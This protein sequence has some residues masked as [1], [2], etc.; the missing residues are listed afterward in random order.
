MRP[1]RI[2][3]VGKYYP[4]VP[5]GMERFLGDLVEA[6]RAAGHD[7]T[8]LVHAEPRSDRS[9]DPPWILRCP[10][11]LRLIFAPLS[12][13]FYFW[14]RRIV[15]RFRP[16]VIHLHVPNLSAFWA[17]LVPGARDVAWVLHWQSD[18]VPSARK[19]A[20]RLAYPH[21]RIFERALLERADAVIVSS[22]QYLAGSK[23]LAPWADKC[24]VIP[25]AIDPARLPDVP[26]EATE[27]LWQGRGMRVLAV[28]RLT[29]YKGFETLIRAVAGMDNAELLLVGDGEERTQL[30]RAWRGAG[31]PSWVRMQGRIDDATL[32]RLMS[33]CDVFCLPSLERTE[34]FGIVL[35]EAMRYGKPLVASDLRDS[36]MTYVV[37]GGQNGLLVPAENV[38]ALR[39]A[40][41]RLAA[42][43]GERRMLGR[44]GHERF[45]REF[46]IAAVERRIHALYDLLL[47]MRVED[48]VARAGLGDPDAPEAPVEPTFAVPARTRLLAVIPALNEADCI[49]EVI[50]QARAHGEVD[51][52]VVDDGSTD[53][54]AAVAMLAGARVLR[55]PL[56]QGAWG[57]IQTGIRYAVRHGYSAVVTMDADGQ[58][59]PSYLPQMIAAGR[60]ADVVIAACPSRGSRMRHVAWAYFRFLTG[61]QL[62]DLTSGFRLYNQRACR[63]LAMEEATLLDYQDLGVLLLLR[64]ANL[65][66]AEISVSMNARRSGASRVFSS[67]WTV[68]RYMVETSLLCLARWNFRPRK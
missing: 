14:L 8:V 29:Y 38:T 13:Q 44:L 47:R 1:L 21:Y 64:R 3:H 22:P 48:A 25:L 9:D 45:L 61:L 59:E 41:S 68:G 49:A 53:D 31:E 5:G 60:S 55:A 46:T 2:L 27:G 51:V 52:L 36:G 42:N 20:L 34:S 65:S 62:D 57:A 10:V 54:T 19:L 30:T 40:L 67:W 58:H 32:A 16:D 23:A 63:L 24:H 50:A 56:W 7:V 28:G 43:P 11:W 15:R 39:A 37:R 12:P 4:P 26:A 17:L 18:V 33:S 6:Q 66:I 35:L